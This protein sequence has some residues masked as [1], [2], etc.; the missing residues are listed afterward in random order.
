[1]LETILGYGALCHM[2][3]FEHFQTKLLYVCEDPE[4]DPDLERVRKFEM[5]AR[6]L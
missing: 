4:H 5:L 2:F 1:M 6:N 3:I